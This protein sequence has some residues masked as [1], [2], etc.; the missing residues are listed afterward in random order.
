[1]MRDNVMFNCNFSGFQ[2][3]YW[4]MLFRPYIHKE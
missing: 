1:M 3:K 4:D 2:N